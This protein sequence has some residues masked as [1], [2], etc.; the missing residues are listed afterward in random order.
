MR[1]VEEL[2]P[3]EWRRR[4]LRILAAARHRRTA[5]ELRALRRTPIHP[6][7]ERWL[8]YRAVGG[9]RCR[10]YRVQPWPEAVMIEPPPG[11]V[12]HFAAVINP[13]TPD[14]RLRGPAADI[15]IIDDPVRIDEVPPQMRTAFGAWW[16]DVARRERER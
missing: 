8:R 13:Y 2:P 6:A 1:R 15:V 3:R 4:H 5:A 7:Y 11:G 12:P 9:H 14:G 10:P 16:A